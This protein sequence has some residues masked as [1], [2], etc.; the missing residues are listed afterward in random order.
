MVKPLN[1]LILC[2]ST[3][4][5]L[6]GGSAAWAA[7]ISLD[8]SQISM[9]E[10]ATLSVEASDNAELPDDVMASLERNFHVT[11]RGESKQVSCINLKCDSTITTSYLLEPKQ[12]GIF[13]IPSFTLGGQTIKARRIQVNAVNTD[14]TK[15]PVDNVFAELSVDKQKVSLQQQ[16]LLTIKINTSIN[17]TDLNLEPLDIPNTLLKELE[18][19]SYQRQIGGKLFQTYEIRYALFPQTIGALTIPPATVYIA[20]PGSSPRGFRSLFAPTRQ[21]RLRTNGA[22]VEVTRPPAHSGDWLPAYALQLQDKWSKDLNDVKVG[23]SITRTI[24]TTAMGLS[25]EQLPPITMQGTANYK[26]Y[27]DQPSTEDRIYEEGVSG[28]HTDTLA[29]VPTKAGTF[30]LPAVKLEWWNITQQKMEVST[31]R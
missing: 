31:L 20:Q 24:T 11:N 26:V 4:C 17:L 6:L 3:A 1:K 27:P 15:G 29:L 19:K 8:R 5:L 28:I 13:T 7:K 21:E 12:P 18:Q 23:D 25:A 2:V 22:T 10:S 16:V 14:P 9:N 30:T